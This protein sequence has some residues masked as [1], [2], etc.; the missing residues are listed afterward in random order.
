MSKLTPSGD[1]SEAFTSHRSFLGWAFGA[2]VAL[3]A[4]GQ[5][6]QCTRQEATDAGKTAKQGIQI[7]DGAC[8]VAD[9]VENLPDWLTVVCQGVDGAT[10][11]T[12]PKAAWYAAKAATRDAGPD[13]A[14]IGK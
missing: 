12:M 1:F 3:F 6:T 11:V 8:K 7:A 13:A 10:R 5:W 2:F 9:A 4:L 14:P